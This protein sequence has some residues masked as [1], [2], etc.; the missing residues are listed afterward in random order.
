MVNVR[1]LIFLPVVIN[2]MKKTV[3]M[4]FKPCICIA[5]MPNWQ[6]INFVVSSLTFKTSGMTGNAKPLHKHALGT[7][8]AK[9]FF[10]Q[11]EQK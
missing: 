8:P 11:V 4:L 1:K 2:P 10:W 5:C 7:S 9:A 3:S 6:V